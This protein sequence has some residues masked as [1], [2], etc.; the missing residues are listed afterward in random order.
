MYTYQHYNCSNLTN[1][2]LEQL[3]HPGMRP[4]MQLKQSIRD[5]KQMYGSGTL[6]HVPKVFRVE[7]CTNLG[8]RFFKS[9]YIES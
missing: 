6:S 2:D 3:F 4:R 8:F 7:T 9:G 1:I 5:L